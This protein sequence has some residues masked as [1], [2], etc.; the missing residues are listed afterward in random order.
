MTT[1][2]GPTLRDAF[3][4]RENTAPTSP[5]L[6]ITPDASLR[7]GQK[8]FSCVSHPNTAVV[9]KTLQN[10]DLAL[11][12][13]DIVERAHI[14]KNAVRHEIERLV[15]EGR[16]YPVNR[17]GRTR[18]YQIAPDLRQT[19]RSPCFIWQKCSCGKWRKLKRQPSG[20]YRFWCRCGEEKL[21]SRLTVE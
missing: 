7:T 8:A 15:E 12:R 6:E 3:M 1:L 5:P 16:V 2:T 14:S 10:A 13:R 21:V 19:Y 17:P 20:N 9:L 11:S 4:Q 18:Y